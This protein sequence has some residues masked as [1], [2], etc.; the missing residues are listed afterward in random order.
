MFLILFFYSFIF[1]IDSKNG[2]N[3]EPNYIGG[4]STGL[5]D[6]ASEFFVKQNIKFDILTFSELSPATTDIVNGFMSNSKGDYTYKLIGYESS[7]PPY[8]AAIFR[9]AFL[10]FKTFNH[11]IY[12]DEKILVNRYQNQP[13]KFFIFIENLPL[14]QLY[15]S[16]F[17]EG[18][19]QPTIF[20]QGIIL[21]GIFIIQDLDKIVLVTVE[22]FSPFECNQVQ[23]HKL[24]TFYL[25]TMTWSKQLKNYEKFL[26]Y[27]GCE[28]V[29]ML[30][31]A[32]IDGM[33]YHVSGYTLPNENFTD[34]K[35]FGLTPEVFKIAAKF[36]N[37]TTGFQPADVKGSFIATYDESEAELLLINGTL[38]IPH[39]Y[40]QV[41]ST[42][43]LTNAIRTSNI[44]ENDFEIILATPAEKYSVY[45]KFALPFD[46][47]TWILI[48]V[49]FLVTFSTI[50][51]VNCLSQ[52]VRN[53][54]FGEMINNPFWNVVSIFFGI[55]QTKLPAVT[56]AR[57]ILALFIWFCLIF[58]TCFQ[59]KFFEFM[60]SELR[61]A[62]PK[63]VEDLWEGNYSIY[64][65]RIIDSYK[66][67][68]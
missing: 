55:S 65:V 56:F 60:T 16:K 18:Y 21:N 59:S 47:E 52:S 33:L 66:M 22:W 1:P 51:V 68:R 48:F 3:L 25:K 2:F 58:R 32:G 64:E 53:V 13:T 5:T 23:F 50:F 40:F 14:Q 37:F 38:K 41:T 57:F 44:F 27:Y 8:V 17:P 36:H 43:F 34:F 42:K 39:V 28:L 20:A 9:S 12:F 30:P 54:V 26:Q 67:A 15:D 7:W 63:C 10:F 35:I 19:S 6:V 31:M 29:L 24:N 61:R 11:L 62:P 46:T 45:E 4:I 49:T